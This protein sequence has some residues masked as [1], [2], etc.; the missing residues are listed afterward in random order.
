[1]YKDTDYTQ[2]DESFVATVT[3][4]TGAKKLIYE[5]KEYVYLPGQSGEFDKTDG[6]QLVTVKMKAETPVESARYLKI[7][8]STMT[9][10][11]MK[12]TLSQK[13]TDNIPK[14]PVFDTKLSAKFAL[15]IHSGAVMETVLSTKTNSSEV[16][17]EL[18][19]LSTDGGAAS[20]V[21]VFFNTNQLK[22]EDSLKY[23]VH[24]RDPEKAE[25]PYR[26]IELDVYST[27]ITKLVF[28][29]R[30]MNDTITSDA[31]LNAGESVTDKD[32]YY[33]IVTYEE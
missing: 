4:E 13:L 2:M 1:M 23:Q 28:F 20:R 15:K 24:P 19:C 16:I 32:I 9:A 8:A 7:T 18:R 5:G 31:S 10:A 21:K 25:D 30:R 17:Y 29:K 6:T 3:Y 12:D 27:S 11:Q 26:Y 33:E 14:G 22:F